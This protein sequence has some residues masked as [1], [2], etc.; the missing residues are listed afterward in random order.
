[1]PVRVGSSDAMDSPVCLPREIAALVSMGAGFTFTNTRSL[2]CMLRL[3]PWIW[4][5]VL[6]T[7][8]CR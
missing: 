7:D 8:R 2:T 5:R 4:P 1:M 3:W 6:P